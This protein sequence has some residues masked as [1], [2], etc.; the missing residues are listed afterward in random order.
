MMKDGWNLK[1]D[2][3]LASRGP[4]VPSFCWG[5]IAHRNATGAGPRVDGPCIQMWMWQRGGVDTQ[6]WKKDGWFFLG[7]LV[8]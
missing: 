4:G 6:I 2:F 8:V 1:A 5:A 7:Q 3:S